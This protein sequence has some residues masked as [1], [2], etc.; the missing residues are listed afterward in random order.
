MSHTV[1]R[2]RWCGEDA[3]S[4]RAGQTTRRRKK[5]TMN[6][7]QGLGSANVIFGLNERLWISVTTA[8]RGINFMRIGRGTIG[9][10]QNAV[11]CPFIL[12]EQVF[13]VMTEAFLIANPDTV[14]NV[15]ALENAD[16]QR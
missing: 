16:G 10:T 5:T 6:E 3:E 8:D 2:V 1:N 15:V 12:L 11:Q 7:K 14:V 9:P 13:R 4:N